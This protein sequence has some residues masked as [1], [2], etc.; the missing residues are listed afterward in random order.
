MN[1][2]SKRLFNRQLVGIICTMLLVISGLALSGCNNAPMTGEKFTSTVESFGYRTTNI[3]DSAQKDRTLANPEFIE[4][5]IAAQKGS[6]GIVF[7]QFS[8]DAQ[9]RIFYEKEDSKYDA[10]INSYVMGD[11]PD[12]NEEVDSGS[13]A[14]HTLQ[15]YHLDAKKDMFNKVSLNGNIVV[16]AFANDGSEETERALNKLGY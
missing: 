9:A 4:L 12:E 13:I 3:T 15:F 6:T 5:A 7:Y 1:E 2:K 16:K 10:L 11:G 14:H 8:D